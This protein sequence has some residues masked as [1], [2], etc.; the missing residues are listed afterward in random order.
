ML[1]TIGQNKIKLGIKLERMK[2]A[3]ILFIK[4]KIKEE[5]DS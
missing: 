4:N 1:S 3:S 2:Q 5:V